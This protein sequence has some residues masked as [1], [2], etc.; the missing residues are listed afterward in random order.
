MSPVAFR[1]PCCDSLN[2]L[3]PR[4]FSEIFNKTTP[5]GNFLSVDSSVFMLFT[6]NDPELPRELVLESDGWAAATAALLIL[7]RIDGFVYAG[8]LVAVFIVTASPEDLG[9]PI[10]VVLNWTAV[11]KR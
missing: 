10:T 3:S 1:M 8:V 6:A 5:R 7:E 9:P 4:F 11:L 2:T